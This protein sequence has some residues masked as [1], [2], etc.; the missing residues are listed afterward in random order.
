MRHSFFQW[1]SVSSVLG[2]CAPI[3]WLIVN[4][5]YGLPALL[6]FVLIIFWPTSIWLM[7]TDGIE[8]T[9]KA[10]LFILM[11]VAANVVLYAVLGTIVWSVTYVFSI[12]VSR[13]RRS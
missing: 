5:L 1:L 12:L 4:W 11:A 2:L 8:G 6:Y 13:H 9:S 10:Y 3:I 7:A